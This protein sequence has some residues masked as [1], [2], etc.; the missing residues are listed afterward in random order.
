MAGHVMRS[1]FAAIFPLQPHRLV[2]LKLSAPRC[3]WWF[4][5]NKRIT[6]KGQVLG[7][8]GFRF[9]TLQGRSKI[10]GRWALGAG[11][12]TRPVQ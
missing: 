9:R 7:F 12:W 4:V 8:P 1:R 6:L 11:R 3:T 10:G 2:T 5:L